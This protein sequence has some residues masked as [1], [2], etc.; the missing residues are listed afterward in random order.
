MLS[1]C[2]NV[3]CRRRCWNC[4]F[5]LFLLCS[6]LLTIRTCSTPSLH[7]PR[8]GGHWP[9]PRDRRPA[10][11]VMP[12]S[13]RLAMAV[14]RHVHDPPPWPT[15]LTMIKGTLCREHLASG[16]LTRRRT[17]QL[18]FRSCSPAQVYSPSETLKTGRPTPSGRPCVIAR[19]LAMPPGHTQRLHR[20]RHSVLREYVS[21]R[22]PSVPH[23]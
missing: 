17:V 22:R 6:G 13:S 15:G 1:P 12:S 11:M 10:C 23:R 20:H 16:Y 4:R 7:A 8:I 2:R 14:R 9:A 19:S 21:C 5:G 18:F 3:L